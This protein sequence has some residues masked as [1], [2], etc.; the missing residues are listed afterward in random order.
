MNI[1]NVIENIIYMLVI[2]VGLSVYT[3]KVLKPII[4]TSIN[5]ETTKIENNIK[6]EIENKFKKINELNTDSPINITPK[7]NIPEKNSGCKEGTV[8]IPIKNLTRRQKRRLNL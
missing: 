2:F 8:C 6:T 3:S 5:K 1:K 4:I 7:S